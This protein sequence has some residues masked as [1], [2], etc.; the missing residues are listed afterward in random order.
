MCR[1]SWSPIGSRLLVSPPSDPQ[2]ASARRRTVDG[3]NGTLDVVPKT[4]ASPSSSELVGHELAPEAAEDR[5][6]AS[7]RPR[8]RFDLPVGVVP[9]ALNA[10]ETAVE[11]DVRPPK[12]AKLAATQAGVHR[13]RP[14]RAVGL[15]KRLDQR[16]TFAWRSDAIT[17]ATR[18]GY[19][20]A[21][22]GVHRNLLTREGAAVH[23]LQWVEGVP[24]GARVES[25]PR[26]LSTS[27]WTSPR[28]TSARRAC[29]SAGI[30]RKR[31]E[32]S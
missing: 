26:S 16:R 32:R 18:R 25:L 17:S 8:L 28:V 31:S 13:R 11:V 14:N 2:A 21:D 3:S 30:T 23:R 22:R 20:E 12:S 9:A 19:L 6:A 29:P 15:R 1:A 7:P 24:D 10:D 5:D 27:A 4:R